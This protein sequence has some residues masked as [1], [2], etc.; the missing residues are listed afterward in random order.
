MRCIERVIGGDGQCSRKARN[1]FL[2]C[3][4]HMRKVLKS[5]CIE[6][7]G[8]GGDHQCEKPATRNKLYC[9]SH[10][11]KNCQYTTDTDRCTRATVDGKYCD[12]HL[13]MHKHDG[14]P[15]WMLKTK[16]PPKWPRGKFACIYADPAW[17]FLARSPKGYGRSAQRHYPVM[18]LADIK[19]LPVAEIAAKD[20][21]LFLWATGPCLPQA[22]EVAKAWGFT[23]SGLGFVWL[24]TYRNTITHNG[25]LPVEFL[26][27]YFCF[28]PGFT[29]RKNAEIVLLFKR[30][31]PKRNSASVRELVIAQRREHSR[32]PDAVVQ[33]IEQF[34]SGLYCELFAR[35]GRR[36]GW[37]KWGDEKG[38]FHGRTG[39]RLLRGK[40]TRP[41]K[42]GA[43]ENRVRAKIKRR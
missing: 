28:G 40:K 41:R 12:R 3:A 4:G 37:T 7:V 30:G 33:R 17:K 10:L 6:R 34:C 27:P 8:P 16:R 36:K 9:R 42:M 35:S 18:N 1:G 22:F 32:K 43:P 31:H 38:K 2:Y 14:R 11:P 21:W 29:T 15:P 19:A 13:W 23:Y 25:T 39:T 24:K 20:C 5:R 26:E